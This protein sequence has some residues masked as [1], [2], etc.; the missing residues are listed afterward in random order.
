MVQNLFL[1]Q[2]GG[3]SFTFS[4]TFVFLD[5]STKK[6]QLAV[7]LRWPGVSGALPL[8]IASQWL[9]PSSGFSAFTCSKG[10]HRYGHKIG[11]NSHHGI[12]EILDFAC[13]ILISW[14]IR[15]LCHSTPPFEICPNEIC[16]VNFMSIF[17]T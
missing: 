12:L 1:N 9:C 15:S 10:G 4:A 13:C 16:P 6:L 5:C 17:P 2:R 11:F 3:K 14:S 8:H 7:P